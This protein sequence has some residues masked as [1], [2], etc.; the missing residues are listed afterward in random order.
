M[1][2]D[3]HNG[4]DIFAVII[5]SAAIN[6]SVAASQRKHLQLPLFIF[7]FL[8]RFTPFCILHT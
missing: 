2:M 7:L 8:V 6:L 5:I 4:L 3:G 1:I